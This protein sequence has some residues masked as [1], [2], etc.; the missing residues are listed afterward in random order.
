MIIVRGYELDV[1]FLEELEQFDIWENKKVRGIKFI[2]CSP[3]RRERRPSFA[4]NLEN[5]TWIDSGAYDEE[6][7][8]GNFVKLLSWLRE[9]TYEDTAEYLIQKYKP[10]LT[11][12]TKLKL[13][14][15]IT[16]DKPEKIILPKDILKPYMYRSPYLAKRGISE[17]VQRAFKIG[18][19]K[20][21]KAIVIP[22]FDKDGN[23]VNLKFRSIVHKYF[24]FNPIGDGIKNHVYGLHFIRRM[25]LNKAFIVEAEI[26][27][28]YLWT[29]GIPAIALG[30]ANM[31]EEQRKLILNSPIKTLIIATD[32]DKAGRHI[33]S[34]IIKRLGGYLNLRKIDLPNGVKDVNE[35]DSVTLI[36]VCESHSP[37]HFI[38]VK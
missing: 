5:G 29:H 23:I 30:G 3:F 6:W 25:N 14:L 32:N 24:W 9:E 28:M 22:I 16:M 17:K 19:D 26:D 34:D 15:K 10:N 38:N 1:D 18:Y 33:A 13:D 31:S 8:K 12:V 27:C 20:E 2:A 35:L 4:V 11:D 21:K 36:S 7:K 37:I